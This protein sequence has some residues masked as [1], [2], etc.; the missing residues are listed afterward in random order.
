MLLAVVSLVCHNLTILQE[1]KKG[2]LIGN[3][4]RN[5]LGNSMWPVITSFIKQGGPVAQLKNVL[6]FL[7]LPLL[8]FIML[9]NIIEMSR[10]GFSAKCVSFEHQTFFT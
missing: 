4:T 3:M 5:N 1:M 8:D 9:Q 2:S 10:T 6:T 7:N